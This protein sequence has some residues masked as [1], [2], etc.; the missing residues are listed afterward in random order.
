MLM[1]F[2]FHL[3]LARIYGRGPSLGRASLPP[4]RKPPNETQSENATSI[5]NR[6]T[7]NAAKKR[8]LAGLLETCSKSF[9]CGRVSRFDV[10][11][12]ASRLARR[13][14]PIVALR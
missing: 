10:F 8:E 6:L 14:R 4:A 5:A 12:L 13:S 3:L 11:A 7:L 1:T 2:P 9:R